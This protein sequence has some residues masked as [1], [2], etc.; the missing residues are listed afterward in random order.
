MDL[1]GTNFTLLASLCSDP[2]ARGKCCR[3]INAYVALSVARYANT[4][5]NLGIGPDLSDICLRSM[6]ET[7][8]LYGVPR[9]ATGFCGFG[10]KV[11]LNYECKDRTTVTQMLQSPGFNG[12]AETCQVPPSEKSDCRKCINASIMYL[13]QITAAEDNVTLITCRDATFVTLASQS[14]NAS[15]IAFAACFFGVPR[16]TSKGT[17]FPMCAIYLNIM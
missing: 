1:S 5:S 10:T 11:P 6:S 7:L 4:T 8:G 3:Y 15:A 17:V 16:I 2:D 9:N 14:D 12:V 13:R